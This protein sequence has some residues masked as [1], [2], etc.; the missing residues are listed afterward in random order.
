MGDLLAALHAQALLRPCP[1]GCAPS[2]RPCEPPRRV[3]VARIPDPQ[4][5]A[6]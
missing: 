1:N 5:R 6:P 3:C 4:E 2:G